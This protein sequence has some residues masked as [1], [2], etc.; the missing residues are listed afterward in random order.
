MKHIVL[1][2]GAFILFNLLFGTFVNFDSN[3]SVGGATTLVDPGGATGQKSLQ[4]RAL[5]PVTPTPGTPGGPGSPTITP[6]PPL[7]QGK[8]V[9]VD[10]LLDTS[11]SM[12]VRL[13]QLKE[14][15][16][17][18]A[19]LL[20]DDV[21]IGAQQ[22]NQ[23]ASNILTPRKNQRA[24]LI[25]SVNQLSVASPDNTYMQSGFVTAQQEIN[26]AR[27]RPEHAGMRWWLIFLSDG[28]PNDSTPGEGPDPNQDP[29]RSQTARQIGDS[30]VDIITIGVALD[31][32]NRSYIW[33][34]EAGGDIVAYAKTLMRQVAKPQGD[35]P[36]GN[37]HNA[38][39]GA[40]LLPILETIARDICR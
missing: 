28:V 18:F 24:A 1:F 21:A 5:V 14:A 13:T 27:A 26:A 34:L 22:F 37:F 4:L 40:Q 36:A 11:G 29:R 33:T 31:G 32:L 25:S 19:N 6:I 17:R 35:Y 12:S 9:G 2:I 20:G 30:G 8:N 15:V 23:G 7:C 38:P 39:S 10:L 3:Y 16:E